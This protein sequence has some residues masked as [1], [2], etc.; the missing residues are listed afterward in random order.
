M[1]MSSSSS[2]KGN[3]PASSSPRTGLEAAEQRVA[4]GL[5]EDPAGG[6]HRRVGARAREVLGPQAPVEGQGGVQGLEGRGLRLGEA[7][8]GARV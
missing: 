2:R 7:R 1:W 3:D 8:H 6:E 4:L 5:G